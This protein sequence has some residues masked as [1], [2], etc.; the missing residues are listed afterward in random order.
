MNHQ[1]RPF[2][3][4]TGASSGIGAVYADRLARRGYDLI[5]VA[6]REDRLKTL[7][8]QIGAATG[9]A[10]ETVVADLGERSSLKRVEEILRSNG[11]ISLLVN[12]AGTAAVTP[13]LNSNVNAMSAMIDLNVNALMRL[14]YAAAPGFV[15]RGGGTIINI[16]SIVAVGPEVLNGVYGATKSFVVAFSQSLKHELTDKGIQVQV[17]LP[18]ATATDLWANAGMPVENLPKEIVM[19]TEAMVDAA[20]AGLD[21]GEFVTVPALADIQQWHAFE[22]GRQALIPLLSGSKPAERYRTSTAF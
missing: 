1:T 2:A 22:Q 21:L 13:L 6:R 10:V 3:L 17:V 20:L 12:N 15:Q 14:S 18:G 7:A 19:Q 11:S 4:V 8:K 16:A 9:A 5:L